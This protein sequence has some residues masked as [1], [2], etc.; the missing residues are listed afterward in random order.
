MK[1]RTMK[2]I[3]VIVGLLLLISINITTDNIMRPEQITLEQFAKEYIP[4][5]TLKKRIPLECRRVNDFTVAKNTGNIVVLTDGTVNYFDIDG[6]LMWKKEFNNVYVLRCFISENGKIITLSGTKKH[7]GNRNPRMYGSIVMND[8]GDILFEKVLDLDY[9]V[10]SPNG[11]YFTYAKSDPQKSSEI[12][13]LKGIKILNQEG[14]DINIKGFN[15]G[16]L[17]DVELYFVTNKNIVMLAKDNTKSSTYFYFF[18]I[19]NNN[20]TLL[21]KYE[22]DFKEYIAGYF[23]RDIKINKGKDKMI[24]NMYNCPVYVFNF[25]GDLLYKDD[26]IHLN[27]IAFIDDENI[28]LHRT[29]YK[30]KIVNLKTKDVEIKPKT[31]FTMPKIKE[32]FEINKYLLFSLN[33]AT[34]IIKRINWQDHKGFT[35]ASKNIVLDNKDYFI[36]EKGFNNPEIVIYERSS[37]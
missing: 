16:N 30:P 17:V 15:Y 32:I 18:K 28:Y 21:W 14:K 29:G 5:Y 7:T 26:E 3:C 23:H 10:P 22:I 35:Y 36:F 37:K 4:D 2:K 1:G 24:I 6:K 13:E 9:I 27:S 33:D 31:R 20:L 19:D 12:K 11:K 25:A 8:K 34:D